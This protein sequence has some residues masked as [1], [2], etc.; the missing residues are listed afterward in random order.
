[1][2]GCSWSD[3]QVPFTQPSVR[4]HGPTDGRHGVPSICRES[5]A[6]AWQVG[7]SNVRQVPL[8]AQRLLV[9]SENEVQLSE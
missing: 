1:L 8:P 5:N 3:G 6:L 2:A 4:S 9:T 7:K